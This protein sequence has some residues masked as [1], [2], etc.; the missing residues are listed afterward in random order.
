MIDLQG[1]TIDYARIS[2]TDKC[3]L[4]CLYCM[5]EQGVELL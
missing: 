4:R 2:V 1:R 5:P 3:N